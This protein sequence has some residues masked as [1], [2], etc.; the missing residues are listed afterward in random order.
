MDNMKPCPF[1]GGTKLKLDKKKIQNEVALLSFKKYI[2][3]LFFCYR[4]YQNIQ[5]E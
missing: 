5:G 4:K 3:K 2:F 1:C